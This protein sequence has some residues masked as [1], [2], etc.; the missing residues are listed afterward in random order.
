MFM[1]WRQVFPPYVPP[2]PIGPLP[3]TGKVT[4]LAWSNTSASNT[5]AYGNAVVVLGGKIYAI[6]GYQSNVSLPARG[7]R[8]YTPSSNTWTYQYTGFTGTNG[9]ITQGTAV[10]IGNTIYVLAGSAN[11]TRLYSY[12]PSTGVWAV[13]AAMSIPRRYAGSCVINDKMYV[14]G[15]EISD[16]ADTGTVEIYDP[17]TNKWSKGASCGKNG[18]PAVCAAVNGI[19]YAWIAANLYKYD[20][21]ANK[22]TNLGTGRSTSARFSSMAAVGTDLFLYGGTNNFVYYND[23]WKYNTLT[24]T[25]TQLT[26]TPQLPEVK[27]NGLVALDGALYTYGGT[28]TGNPMNF[29][30]IT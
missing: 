24:N 4:T 11:T 10:A 21:V 22:W 23:L 29:F 16:T 25:W 7:V 2:A 30:K 17:V 1:T 9:D 20:P 6:G 3:I 12:V 5:N 13:K 14:V 15:S 26:S 18:Y 19:M 27:W 28:Y 8:T